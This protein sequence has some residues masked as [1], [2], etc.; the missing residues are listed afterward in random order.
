MPAKYH[1]KTRPMPPRKKPIGKYGI[2]DWSE[3]CSSCRNC[4]KRE[5]VFDC[6]KNEDVALHEA[7]DF[8]DYLYECR[9][10]LSCVQSCTKGLLARRINPEYL[11]LGDDFW[12]P[13]VIST[14]Q[15]QAETG[16][17]PVSGAGYHGPFSG[18]GFDGMWTDM[19]E[20]VRPTRD[21]IHGREYISTAVDF[22]RKPAALSFDA[23]GLTTKCPSMLS[24]P[25]PMIFDAMS[26]HEPPTIVRE[27]MITAAS[28]LGTLALIEP[29]N[30]T[31]EME[32]CAKSIGLCE[33]CGDLPK[34]W[35]TRTPVVEFCA[36]D[37]VF[38][39]IEQAKAVN[40]N[41]IAM[42]RLQS[43]AEAGE[44]AVELAQKGAEVIHLAANS[45]GYEYGPASRHIRDAIRDVHIKLV[46]SGLRDE[47]TL[48]VSGGIALAEHVAK[49]IICGADLVAVDIPLMIAL[50]CKICNRCK[51]GMS[52]PQELHN[53]DFEYAVQRMVNLMAAWHLQMIEV[54]GAMG[55]REV[56]R[57]R[58]EVGRAMFC[59]E[60]EKETFGKI[61]G[62]RN[63]EGNND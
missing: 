20:I 34:E 45:D 8:V 4:V 9:S 23:N 1:V 47:V 15:F 51:R 5:C 56:R 6:Y 38:T 19:S 61:F 16:K 59:D 42:I 35:L 12:T 43:N 31:P 50:E 54:L 10:C 33:H 13:D 32:D 14:T 22:G 36:S 48:V 40:P 11:R 30:L 55:I 60:L 41:V 28:R 62:N 46:E 49:A 39:W 24:L 17:V 27:A 53:V 52:C 57:L 7:T 29:H 63:A 3:D 26:W 18:T 2:V 25:I 37:E 58:G 21:G 44:K